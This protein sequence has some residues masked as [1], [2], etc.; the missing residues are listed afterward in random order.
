[1]DPRQYRREILRA[2]GADISDELLYCEEMIYDNPK[3]YQVWHHRKTLVNESGKFEGE[4]AFTALQLQ[5]EPKN[6]H[7]WQ[8]RLGKGIDEN[9]CNS[10]F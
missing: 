1:L 7:A 9:N 2:L 6:Y 3:N 10:R 4:L 5:E 8:Y